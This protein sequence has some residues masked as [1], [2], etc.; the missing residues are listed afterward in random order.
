MDGSTLSLILIPIVV[1]I[2]L[3]IWLIMVYYADSHP[4]R[5]GHSAA[6]GRARSASSDQKRLSD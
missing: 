2:S 1:T 3:A 6:T 5:G 4:R